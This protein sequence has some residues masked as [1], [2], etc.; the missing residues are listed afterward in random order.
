[1]YSNAP[2]V[3]DGERKRRCDK[4]PIEY[5]S[6]ERSSPLP[7]EMGTFWPSNSNKLLV[8]KLIYC[9][10]RTHAHTGQYPTVLGQVTTADEEWQ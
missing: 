9:H 2:L 3:K 4:V 8:E 7:Q 10:L 5:S 6:I 1:M